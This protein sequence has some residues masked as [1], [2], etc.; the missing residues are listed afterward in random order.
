[1]VCPGLCFTGGGDNFHKDNNFPFS[2]S[3]VVHRSLHERAEVLFIRGPSENILLGLCFKGRADE[4]NY[5]VF[6]NRATLLVYGTIAPF[7]N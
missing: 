7:I 2:F 3:A 6:G 4:D 5:F 1:M